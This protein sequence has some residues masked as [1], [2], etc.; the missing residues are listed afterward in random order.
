M[1]VSAAI[2]LAAMGTISAQHAQVLAAQG[3]PVSV[4]LT[5]GFQLVFELAAA[6]VTAGLAVVLI[7]LRRT[8]DRWRHERMHLPRRRETSYEETEAA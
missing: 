2:G 7:V 4:A 8:D 5:G 3:E 6:C 1:Q